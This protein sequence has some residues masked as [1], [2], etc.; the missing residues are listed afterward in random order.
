MFVASSGTIQVVDMPVAVELPFFSRPETPSVRLAC[1]SC[2]RAYAVSPGAPAARCQHC[3]ALR[4][5]VRSERAV[6]ISSTI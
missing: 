3:S 2:G 4:T 5:S 1:W 6:G